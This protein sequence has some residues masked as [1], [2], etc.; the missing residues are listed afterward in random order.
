MVACVG[1][2][3]NLG[4]AAATLLDD[5]SLERLLALL[6]AFDDTHHDL[7]AV[8]HAE[9]AR[10]LGEHPLLDPVHEVHVTSSFKT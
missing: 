6:V 4:D 9:V 3:G 1:L 7:D 2:G 8:A 5:D 10:L